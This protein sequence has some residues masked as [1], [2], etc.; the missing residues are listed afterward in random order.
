MTNWKYISEVLNV[1]FLLIPQWFLTILQTCTK[2]KISVQLIRLQYRTRQYG[3][4]KV[5][6]SRVRRPTMSSPMV[7]HYALQGKLQK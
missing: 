3:I 2:V 4:R 1:Y 5:T 7:A 6:N